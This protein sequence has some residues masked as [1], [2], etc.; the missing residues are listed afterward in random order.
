[1]KFLDLMALSRNMRK[2][3]DTNTPNMDASVNVRSPY[4]GEDSYEENV[5][6]VN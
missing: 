3:R 5:I 2:S 6:Y 1:M 4:W